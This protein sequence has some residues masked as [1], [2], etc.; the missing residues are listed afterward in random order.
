MNRPLA[1]AWDPMRALIRDCRPGDLL[2]LRVR[3]LSTSLCPYVLLD[4]DAT[5][6][7]T[8]V[9]VPFGSPALVIQR[10]TDGG[11]PHLLVLCHGR[12]GW[13]SY[14]SLGHRAVGA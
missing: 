2:V 8:V 1:D 4:P 13:L 3:R 9:E 14:N 5:E 7:S 6:T 12:V 11:A 10:R